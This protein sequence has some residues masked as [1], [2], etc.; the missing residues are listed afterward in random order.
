MEADLLTSEKWF[1]LLEG[2]RR[3]GSGMYLLGIALG[4]ATIIQVVRFQ[5]IRIRQLASSSI[6]QSACR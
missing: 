6:P 5:S 3:I 2:A 4:L 1:L